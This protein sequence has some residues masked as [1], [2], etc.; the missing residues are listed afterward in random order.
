MSEFSLIQIAILLSGHKTSY[1]CLGN[2]REKE[3]GIEREERKKREKMEEVTC[4]DVESVDAK[5]SLDANLSVSK[6]SAKF[7]IFKCSLMT[8]IVLTISAYAI[9]IPLGVAII[10]ELYHS[11]HDTAFVP[12]STQMSRKLFDRYVNFDY[13]ETNPL[14]IK[15]FK[16]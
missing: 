10:K 8:L 15:L 4:M 1:E 6:S 11:S 13:D 12:A 3:E 9:E 7:F 5:S 16:R 2:R 14:S